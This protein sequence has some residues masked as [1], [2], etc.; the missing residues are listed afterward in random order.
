MPGVAR[1]IFRLFPGLVKG[2]GW[3]LGIVYRLLFNH[4]WLFKTLRETR[5]PPV[6]TVGA[7]IKIVFTAAVKSKGGRITLPRILVFLIQ[8]SLF[9]VALTYNCFFCSPKE[10]ERN[11]HYSGQNTCDRLFHPRNSFQYSPSHFVCYSIM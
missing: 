11:A 4:G 7:Q 1:L 9:S 6:V 8:C 2:L 10:A 3:I 5:K